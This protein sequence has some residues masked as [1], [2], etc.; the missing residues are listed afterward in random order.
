MTTTKSSVK[1]FSCETERLF[2]RPLAEGDEALFD[3][4]YTDPETMRFIAPPL[5]AER[6]L[7]RFR[8]IIMRQRKPSIDGRYL[9]IL[10]RETGKPV[11]IC[12]TSHHDAEAQRLEV[13]MVLVP[14]GRNRGVAKEALSALMKHIFAVSP[15][16]KIEAK[17]FAE[18]QAAERV[19]VS[20]GFTPCADAAGELGV[21]SER[22]WSVHRSSWHVNQTVDLIHSPRGKCECST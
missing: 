21:P 6:A 4:L 16:D 19:L 13:G 1:S 10:E 20:Q 2:L 5:S 3:R 17:V 12:G 14:E 9:V 7:S 8:K 15:V 18:N 11:G 22:R